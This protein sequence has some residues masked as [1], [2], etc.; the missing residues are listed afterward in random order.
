MNFLSFVNYP[1]ANPLSA[2]NTIAVYDLPRRK[3][4]LV[5]SGTRP[6]PTLATRTQQYFGNL[7][8]NLENKT[9]MGL[10]KGVSAA[11]AATKTKDGSSWSSQRDH[12]SSLASSSNTWGL[13]CRDFCET[14]T[15]SP[16]HGIVVPFPWRELLYVVVSRSR[17]DTGNANDNAAV[18][19][20]T[21]GRGGETET[22]SERDPDLAAGAKIIPSLSYLL[23]SFFP[24]ANKYSN[25]DIV[26]Y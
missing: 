24:P 13:I 2:G 21:E 23:R 17:N 14:N 20:A 7:G 10:S 25:G 16:P 5:A 19:N 6:P 1:A 3:S 11:S 15:S 18:R 22:E 26:A 12:S 8:N 4:H 9:F